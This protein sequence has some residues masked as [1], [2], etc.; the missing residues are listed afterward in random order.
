AINASFNYTMHRLGY[1]RQSG[2]AIRR[3]VGWGDKNLLKPF[4]LPKDCNRGLL[5][6]RRHHKKTLLKDSKLY[7]GVRRLLIYLK[8]KGYFL[9]IA[10]NRPLFF[11][12]ILIKHH[13]LEGYFS[14]IVCSD[15]LKQ[16]KPHPQILQRIIEGLSF[17]RKQAVFVGDMLI[18]AQAGRR[19]KVK[20]IIVLSGSGVRSQIQ[21]EKP[22]M[23]IKKITSL[24]RIL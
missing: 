10:S 19:A 12:R 17:S 20:T 6:Y 8:S 18:D 21:K 23:F 7:P 24:L 5:V 3:A 15:T 13:G 16:G 1:P 4:L 11:S 14:S 9:A 2:Q 22:F